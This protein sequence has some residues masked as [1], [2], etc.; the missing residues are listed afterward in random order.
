LNVKG[1]D[2]CPLFYNSVSEADPA[3]SSQAVKRRTKPY[4]LL[5]KPRPL[6]RADIR[7]HGYPKRLK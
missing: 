3:V 2:V 6:A 1:E 4:P 7:L 5:M